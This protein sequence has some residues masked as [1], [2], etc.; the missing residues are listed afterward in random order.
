M[1]QPSQNFG[2]LLKLSDESKSQCGASLCSKRVVGFESSAASNPATRPYLSVTYFPP[3]PSTSKMVLPKE[4]R[5]TAKHLTLEA[6][7]PFPGPT[8]VTYQ[9]K[10]P[11]WTSFQ[12]IPAEL[13]KTKQ[14]KDVTWPLAGGGTGTTSRV[15]VD[16]ASHPWMNDEFEKQVEIRALFE[17]GSG[18][19]YSKPVKTVYD[20]NIGG[21][22]DA[23]AAIGPGSVNLVN[24]SFTLTRTDVSIPA[25]G[26]ALEF[27]RSHSSRTASTPGLSGV[28]GSGW[29]P[30]VPVEAAGG[31]AWQ[32]IYDANAA[33]DGPY[34]VLTDLEGYEYAFEQ[35]GSSYVSPPEASGWLLTRQDSNHLA[36]ADPDGNRM[37]FKKG[38]SDFEYLPI[39][40]SQPGGSNNSTRMVYEFTSDG[41]RRLSMIIGPSAPNVTCNEATAT[42]TLGCRSLTFFYE[43]LPVANDGSYLAARLISISY[44]GPATATTQGHW[45]VSKY[46]YDPS[47]RLIAQWDPRISSPLPLKESYAYSLESP[48]ITTV[49]PAGEEPWTLKYAPGPIAHARRLESVSRPSLLSS[50]STAQ[51]TI[52]YNVPVSGAGAP[53]EM[54]PDETL[55]W[56]QSDFPLTATAVFPPDQVPSSPPSSYSRATVYYMDADGQIVNTATP[57]GAGTSA[58]SITTTETNE[59]GNVTAELTAQNRL[60]ALAAGEESFMQAI[61]LRTERFY[62]AYGS[63]LTL[64]VG[65]KHEVRLESGEVVQARMHKEIEYDKGAPVPPSGT[66]YPRLPTKETVSAYVVDKGKLDKQVTETKYDWTLRKPTE[67]IVD[68]SGLSLRTRIAYDPGTGLPTERSLPAKPEGGDARTTK[69]TYYTKEAHPLDSACGNKPAWASLPCK[70][71]PAAQDTGPGRP[72]LLVTRYL[73]YSLLAQP[74]EVTERSGE[75]GPTRTTYDA[76]GRPLTNKQTGEGASIPKLQFDY[77]TAT[78]RMLAQRFICESNCSGFDDQATTTA[79]DTLGRPIIY[80]DSDGNTSSVT[81]DFLSRPITTSDGKGIQ[82]RTYDPNS[83]LLIKLEDSGAGT[84]TAA[85]DADGNLVE[86]GLPNGL[87]SETTYDETGS[88]VGLRYEKTSFCSVDCTWLEFEVEESI[89]GQW[90][91]QSSNLSTQQYSY[92]KAGRLTQVKDTPHGG[93]CTTRSY[94]FDANSNRTKLITRAPAIGGVCDTTS[95]GSAKEYGYDAADRLMGTDIAYDNFGRTTS[96]PGAYSGGGTLISSYFVNDLVKTQTQGGITNTYELDA[97]LRQRQR[98]QTGGSNPGTEVYHYAGGSDSPAWIDRGSSW[99][100][101]IPGI[102]GLGAIQDSSKGTTLQLTNLHGDVVATASTSPEAPKLLATFGFDEFGNPQQSSEAKYGWLG[103][104]QR[105]T[106]LPSGVTQMGVRSYVPALGRFISLDPVLGGSANSYEYA[107]ADPVNGLDL[108]ELCLYE[109]G[110]PYP[111]ASV[112]DSL[113]RRR[114]PGE[115]LEPR[116]ALPVSIIHIHRPTALVV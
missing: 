61:Y 55:K 38:T 60:R 33:G 65:P 108:P 68:P 89:H 76:A 24:G 26:A 72:G 7:W 35:S 100:R 21:P 111:G 13:V 71:A 20:P 9:M 28:L 56:A 116:P 83:G 97:A 79:Y 86:E 51:T 107:E 58:P 103:G 93:G 10:L 73:G 101:N 5:R 88:R 25:L 23:T 22:L 82:T 32:G 44:H 1:S 66:P 34:V 45:E 70:V 92:D 6:Q 46:S 104:M 87:L 81:Y 91:S 106:E 11:A 96:L 95:T 12:N 94:S 30:S 18:E 39:S 14:G 57:A 105:R 54:G 99:Q 48:M 69:T 64:E 3:A 52:A 17:G 47:G 77:S 37:I 4:G 29:E 84:F 115:P 31:A 40:V 90:L 74:T 63:E 78:G 42:A 85:Y 102:G 110:A 19:G 2:A 59:F 27:S 80:Q 62:E 49:T 8:G 113:S 112:R 16:L 109:P 75:S 50:P 36:L 98:T 67:T 53:Y 114:A 15:Y 41:K 43:D